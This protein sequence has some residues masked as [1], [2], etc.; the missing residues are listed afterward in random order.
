MEDID[1]NERDTERGKETV[2]DREQEKERERRGKKEKGER[3]F[4][5]RDTER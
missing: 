1:R 2:R 3:C 4:N 5:L